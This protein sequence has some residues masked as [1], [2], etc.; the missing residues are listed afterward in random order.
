MDDSNEMDL[1]TDGTSTKAATTPTAEKALPDGWR[2]LTVR[3][4]GELCRAAG[5]P[6]TGKKAE[7]IGRLEVHHFGSAGRP[8][9]G[10]TL[11]TVCKAPARCT[12]TRRIDGTVVRSYRCTGRRRHTFRLTTEE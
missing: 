4:L 2:D 11:C 7:L 8:I 10:R 6:A 5:I 3:E 1:G 12:G 9:H